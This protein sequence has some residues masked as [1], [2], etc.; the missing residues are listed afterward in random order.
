MCIR[1]RDGYC[2]ECETAG[3]LL[4][5]KQ[6]IAPK[7]VGCSAASGSDSCYCASTLDCCNANAGVYYSGIDSATSKGECTVCSTNLCKSCPNDKCVACTGNYTT[8]NVKVKGEERILCV[9]SANG[10]I[11]GMMTLLALFLFI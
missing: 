1:D 6:C 3:N 7:N 9:S 5:F 10:L 8:V 4:V 11:V 2:D